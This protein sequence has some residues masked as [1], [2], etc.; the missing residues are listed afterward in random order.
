[1]TSEIDLEF[2]FPFFDSHCHIDLILDRMKDTDF[3]ELKTRFPSGYRGALQIACDPSR[4]DFAIDLASRYDDIYFAAG[5]HPHEAK[6]Y[7]SEIETKIIDL[8]KHSK[9]KAWGEIGLD[10]HYDYSPREV[11]REVFARQIEK[12][13]ELELPIVL[14]TREADEDTLSILKTHLSPEAKMHVHC[15]TG[16]ADFAREILKLGENIYF[17]FTGVV[18]FKSADSIRQAV[19]EVPA[20]RLLLETDSPFMAPIPFRGKTC[21]P[22]HIPHIGLF[23]AD[24]LQ[25]EAEEFF[26]TCFAN[27]QRL[28]SL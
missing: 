22:G 7:N 9:A 25:R 19:Q 14:H 23:L 18:T 27:T 21:H 13:Q 4:F 8:L 6:D 24:F 26:R 12:A 28:Y 15:F 16:S 1:M 20:E 17:G 10:Y 5:I 2:S 3:N 11:Q